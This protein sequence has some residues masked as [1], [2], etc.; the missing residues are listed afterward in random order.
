AILRLAAEFPIK[1]M[2]PM[3][4]T[5]NEWRQAM[6]L[7]SE[8]RTEVVGRG[9][10]PPSKIETGIMIEVPAAALRAEQFAPVVDFFSIGSND[11][12]QYTLAAE[13]GNSEV[14][15]LGDSLHPAVLQL[16]R[17]V[18]EVA[19]SHGKWVGVC[20]EMAGDPVTVPLL[21]GLGIDELSMNPPGIPLAKQIIRSLDFHT[22][23]N[24]AKASLALENAE[25]V[26]AFLS[27]LETS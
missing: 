23:E 7:L 27:S 16:I 9:W 18:V 11:L 6:K 10:S 8:A 20:G 13:R 15:T 22:V 12:T 14:A 3:V 25:T 24:V 2:F 19:H 1:L 17:H 4:T 21:V 26:R 5:L